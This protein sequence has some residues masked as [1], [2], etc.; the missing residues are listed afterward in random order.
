MANAQPQGTSHFSA[1]P[2]CGVHSINASCLSAAQYVDTTLLL[3]APPRCRAGPIP[4]R[5]GQCP[6]WF[7][8]L[9]LQVGLGTGQ[10]LS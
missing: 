2:S 7:P 10:R 9:S 3:L 5:H 4:G 6:D 1:L 8:Q